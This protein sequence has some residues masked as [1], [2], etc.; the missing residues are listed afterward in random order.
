M[1]PCCAVEA[2]PPG[3][4]QNLDGLPSQ[5]QDH[6]GKDCT[7]GS[8]ATDEAQQLLLMPLEA[9]REPAKENT[10][11]SPLLSPFGRLQCL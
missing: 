5:G 4:R 6:Q 2:G 8:A 3:G 11:D 10:L 1:L 7:A 9:Q